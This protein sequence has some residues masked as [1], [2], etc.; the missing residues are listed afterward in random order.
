MVGCRSISLHFVF[1]SISLHFV[2]LSRVLGTGCN[3]TTS[4]P[5]A[6]EGPWAPGR[7]D[8]VTATGMASNG[9]FT[10]ADSRASS[11]L[12]PGTHYSLT[13]SSG[14]SQLSRSL[15]SDSL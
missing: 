8:L 11:P 15:A 1:L 6:R 10:P 5:T 12:G 14:S 9:Q 4:P 7:E 3:S 13:L 2:F